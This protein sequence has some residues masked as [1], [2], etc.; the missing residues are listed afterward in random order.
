[1][2]SPVTVHGASDW[3]GNGGYGQYVV[4]NRH[5][6][7]FGQTIS[8]TILQDYDYHTYSSSGSSYTS[9][10]SELRTDLSN[11]M[12]GEVPFPVSISEFNVMTGASFST[13]STT[14]DTPANYGNFGGIISALITAATNSS[15]Y[16]FKFSQT[17]SDTGT[18]NL[19][20]QVAKNAMHCSRFIWI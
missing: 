4:A 8:N 5:T 12:T 11:A 10:F 20:A 19:P 1:M 2:Y 14:E 6:N 16:C 18:N 13:V 15:I 3:S 17:Q 9:D 7:F